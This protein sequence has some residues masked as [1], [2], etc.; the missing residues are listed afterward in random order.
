[1][2]ESLQV[3]KLIQQ[4]R[5]FF[6]TGQTKN[7]NFRLEQLKRLK[8]SIINHQGDIIA[9]VKADL[10]RPEFEAYFEIASVSEINYAIKHLKSWT[11][12]KKVRTDRKSVV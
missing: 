3:E 10:N 4:Q 5:Q 11:K 6:A 1:M 9:G 8:Q 2:P 7:V 12:P